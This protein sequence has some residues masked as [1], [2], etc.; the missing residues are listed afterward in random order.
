MKAAWTGC[1]LPFRSRPSIVVMDLPTASASGVRQERRATPLMITVQAPHWPSPQPYFV[2]VK[3]ISS[4][5][6]KRRGMSGSLT[7]EY[8][9]PFTEIVLAAAFAEA[10]RLAADRCA[11]ARF[12]STVV[13]THAPSQSHGWML[14]VY[15]R[16]RGRE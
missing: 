12:A 4:R 5:R 7:T 3:P 1:R 6:T 2:P 8:C 15:T 10:L 9:L 16:D 13:I 14:S 11:P